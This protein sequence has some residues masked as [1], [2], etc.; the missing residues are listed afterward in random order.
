MTPGAA[1]E[2]E[3]AAPFRHRF[4]VAAMLGGE[5]DSEMRGEVH[6]MHRAGREL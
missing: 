1:E 4:Q 2:H 5:L 3:R 6:G